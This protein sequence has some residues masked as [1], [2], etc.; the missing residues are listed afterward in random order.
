MKE[1]WISASLLA[2]FCASPALGYTVSEIYYSM[3]PETI[4]SL[5]DASM[6][7][8]LNRQPFNFNDYKDKGIFSTANL[9]PANAN[10]I[11]WPYWSGYPWTGIGAPGSQ[12]VFQKAVSVS[13][14]APGYG[15]SLF[16]QD[17]GKVG[18]Q[19]N[20]WGLNRPNELIESSNVQFLKLFMDDS[21]KVLPW[22]K[23]NDRLCMNGII[24]LHSWYGPAQAM[25][26][27]HIRDKDS[28]SHHFFFNTLLLDTG[29]SQSNQLGDKVILDNQEDTGAPIAISAAQ[30]NLGSNPAIRYSHPIPGYGD[31]L[32][33]YSKVPYRA[34]NQPGQES[35][36]GFC[37]S[38][39]QL[40]AVLQDTNTVILQFNKDLPTINAQRAARN[41]RLLNPRELFS[42]DVAKYEV[43]MASVAGEIGSSANLGM[44]I[45]KMNLYKLSE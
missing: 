25:M 23:A 38:V 11:P 32:G 4:R 34:E 15:T 30:S 13:G 33:A 5:S 18:M 19:I 39:N 10:M 45:Q 3:A 17:A 41:L 2:M 8:H 40:I 36:Y 29:T 43:D 6:P 44:S 1:K 22:K 42:L 16:Q 12:N 9:L 28:P 37:I 24:N 14:S 20:S 27:L 26:T 21:R 35:H 7:L 31:L